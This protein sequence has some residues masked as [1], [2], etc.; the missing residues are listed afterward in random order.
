[1]TLDVTTALAEIAVECRL[2]NTAEVRPA[3]ADIGKLTVGQGSE[4]GSF[5]PFLPPCGK[6]GDL[7]RQ[8]RSETTVADG[9]RRSC[10]RAKVRLFPLGVDI[11]HCRELEGKLGFSS[12]GAHDE[13]P[14]RPGCNA[15]SVW[16]GATGK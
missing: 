8:K 7:A 1:M 12:V 13:Y 3:D 11:A 9:I 10:M 2:E 4:F 16:R 6:R 15:T 14:Y 5:L